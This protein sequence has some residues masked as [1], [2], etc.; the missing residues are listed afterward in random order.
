MGFNRSYTVSRISQ[1]EQ[2]ILNRIFS[3]IQKS[4]YDSLGINLNWKPNFTVDERSL[5]KKF[6]QDS[7]PQFK[8]MEDFK[9]EDICQKL[10]T[11]KYFSEQVLCYPTEKP[12]GLWFVLSGCLS[13]FEFNGSD[14]A[15]MLNEFGAGMSCGDSEM[16]V[17]V[18]MSSTL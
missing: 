18:S 11:E 10:V 3:K 1:V 4:K 6:I 7:G 8:D 13:V 17:T 9:L 2:T 15:L 5:L 14:E 12:N 16:N